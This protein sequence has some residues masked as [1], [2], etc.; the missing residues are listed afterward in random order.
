MQQP[1]LEPARVLLA[2]GMRLVQLKENTKQP[3]GRAWNKPEHFVQKID[4][5]ASGYG[6]PL[7]ANQLVS[8]DPDDVVAAATGLAG[9]G[10][11][12]TQV[13]AAG[14]RTTSTR[15]GSGGRSTFVDAGGLRWLKFRTKDG[16]ALELRAQSANLQDCV[17]G[18]VYE[19]RDGLACTQTYVGMLTHADVIELDIQLPAGFLEWWRRMSSDPEYYLEQ[20]RLFCEALGAELVADYSTHKELPFASMFRGEFN[21]ENDVAEMLER[22]G[23]E[24]AGEGRFLAPNATGSAGVRLIPGRD[25]LWN[26]AHGSDP[27][28]GNFD[29]WMI[30]VLLEHGGDVTA[31]EEQ[32]RDGRGGLVMFE[33]L[34]PLLDGPATLPNLTLG[35]FPVRKALPMASFQLH[36]KIG[37]AYANLH[38]LT[39]ALRNNA[40]VGY[41]I[42]HD[43]FL[44]E[45]LITEVGRS[46]WRP[47]QNADM[48]EIRMKLERFGFMQIGREIMR[49]AMDRHARGSQVD[50][51]E[52]WL[53]G[54]E[55][56]GVKRVETFMSDYVGA[57]DSAYARAVSAYTWSALAA[58][59]LSPGCQLDMAP[60]WIGEQGVGKTQGLKAMVPAI[61]HYVEIDL[62]SRDTDAARMMRGALLGEL[63]ELKGLNSRDSE[64]IK[65]FITRTHE[66]W[67]PKYRELPTTFPRRLLFI[68]TTNESE[69]LADSTGERRWL[70]IHVGV[71][72]DVDRE[73]IARDRA[74]LW[75]EARVMFLRDGLQY[76]EA[77]RLA[78]EVHAQHKISDPWSVRVEEWLETVDPMTGLAPS[79]EPLTV[80]DIMCG[81]LMM[82]TRDLNRGNQ[83]R[84]AGVLKG[85]GYEKVRAM[86][87]RSRAVR[88]VKKITGYK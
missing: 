1:N 24:P 60:V 30:Y 82:Q 40:S 17:P 11:D 71:T 6:L 15:P 38:N 23:Y 67:I 61:E 31:A 65:A 58:R 70:P 26:S 87:G 56:D 36:P 19:T 3:I 52:Q 8:I 18:L 22:H 28:H 80:S 88:W 68:G 63:A 64:S 42:V 77:E 32:W 48:I 59:V 69:F 76:E 43:L 10:F 51:A 73:A 81:A 21:R 14:V 72:H 79:A 37:L 47:L 85:L 57:R 20:Q 46:D 75:A 55:W 4:D 5:R 62:G 53:S 66:R 9:C 13:M 84:M 54:L 86:V 7:A 41:D 16:I 39:M 83:M 50:C 78:R 29:A 2:A 45:I 74:Q 25:G 49:D 34:G 35:A 12:L 33:D 44:D 27:L